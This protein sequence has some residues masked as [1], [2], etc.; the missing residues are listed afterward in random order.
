MKNTSS[1]KIPLVVLI[2]GIFMGF[3]YRLFEKV[4]R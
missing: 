1:P 2:T 3:M 4:F